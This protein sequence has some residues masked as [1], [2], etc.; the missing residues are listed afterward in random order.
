VATVYAACLDANARLAD[1]RDPA[2]I[3]HRYVEAARFSQSPAQR[4]RM[5]IGVLFPG[6]PVIYLLSCLSRSSL[7]FCWIDFDLYFVQT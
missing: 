7:C 5:Y 3:G 1:V 2:R 4:D 6:T